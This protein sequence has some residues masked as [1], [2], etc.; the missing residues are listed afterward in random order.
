M[1]RSTPARFHTIDNTARRVLRRRDHSC[2]SGKLRYRDH[3]A[4][5]TALHSTANARHL[6]ELN[7]MPT[8]RRESRIYACGLCHGFHLTSQNYLAAA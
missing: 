3:D 5:V 4:A 1:S 8:H 7:G 2:A 6:A